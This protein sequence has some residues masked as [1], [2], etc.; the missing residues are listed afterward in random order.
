MNTTYDPTA[1]AELLASA[2]HHGA[3]LQELPAECRPATL[4][5]GYALQDRLIAVMGTPTAGWKLGMGSPNMMRAANLQRPLVGRLLQSR[6]HPAGATLRLAQPNAPVTVEFEIAFVM[7]RDV[8]PGEAPSDVLDAV[9]A[10]HVAF[11]LVQSR[12]LDRRTVGIPS[13]VGDTVGFGAFVLGAEIAPARIDEVI[14][15]ARV[16]VDGVEH[17]Q[18][19]SGDDLPHPIVSLGYLFDH[20]RERGITLRQGEI[21]T[22]GAVAR[23]FDVAQGSGVALRA[24]YADGELRATLSAI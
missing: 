12:F 7:G 13:F 17:A 22:A 1:A 3:S 16:D 14:A 5:Q 23:P 6:C 8:A 4:A 19:Q 20:A 24:R 2:W 21:V 15:S 10:T 9:A 18:G 11:E